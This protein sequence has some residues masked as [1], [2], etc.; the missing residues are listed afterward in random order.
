MFKPFMFQI[1]TEK[2]ARVLW[3]ILNCPM[4]GIDKYKWL[5]GEEGKKILSY[6]AINDILWVRFNKKYPLK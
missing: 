5:E 1:K 4:S 3:H 6:T 2:E